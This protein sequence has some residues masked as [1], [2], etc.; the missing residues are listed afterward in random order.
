MVVVGINVV[1]VFSVGVMTI[2]DLVFSPDTGL[3][4]SQLT[5]VLTSVIVTSRLEL[6]SSICWSSLYQVSWAAG[7]PGSGSRQRMVTVSPGWRGT[8][9]GSRLDVNLGRPGGAEITNTARHV[10]RKMSLIP[11]ILMCFVFE[12]MILSLKTA[13]QVRLI[14]A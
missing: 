2:L 1:V 13:S 6:A 8:D 3:T 7:R 11:R 5:S 9:T 14:L 12:R 10:K 4:A